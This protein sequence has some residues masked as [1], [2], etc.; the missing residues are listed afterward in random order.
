MKIFVNK[1]Y[2]NVWSGTIVTLLEISDKTGVP[3]CVYIKHTLDKG[4]IKASKR[5][6]PLFYVKPLYVFKKCYS[7]IKEVKP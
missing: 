3:T 4:N 1:D 7:R 5:S 2:K 6:I